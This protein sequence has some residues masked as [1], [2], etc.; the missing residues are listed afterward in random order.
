MPPKYHAREVAGHR[1][2]MTGASVILGSATP[3]LESYYRAQKGRYRLFTLTQR[4]GGAVLPRI[5]VTDLREELERIS[6]SIF[7]EKLTEL[8]EDRLQKREQIIL[9]LNRRGNAGSV[10]CRKCGE[11]L[12]CPHCS[13]SL[14]AHMRYGRLD[15]LVCH[16]CVYQTPMPALCPNCQSK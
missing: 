14:T 8:M 15:Q 13:V 11:V 1:A 12:K 3:S 4:A 5:W 10:S 16:Y 9:F 7:G 2:A 6:R